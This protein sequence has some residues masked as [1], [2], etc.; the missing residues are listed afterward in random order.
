MSYVVR[1]KEKGIRSIGTREELLAF[2]ILCN[3]AKLG[4]ICKLLEASRAFHRGRDDSVPN[5]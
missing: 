1:E 5:F 4:R 3:G 2:G